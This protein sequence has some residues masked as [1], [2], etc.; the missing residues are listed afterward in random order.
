V[1]LDRSALEL[2]TEYAEIGRELR[3]AA[4]RRDAIAAV[5]R[6]AVRRVPGVQWASVT[7]G[8]TGKFRTVA[9][10]DD[11]A[12]MVDEI[13]HRLGSGPCVDAIVEEVTFR[14]GDLRHDDRW[15]GFAREASHDHGI[16]S[17]LSYRL[18][19]EDDDRIVG[20]N[21]YSSKTDAYDDHAEVIGTLVATHGAL[22]IA[23]A[24]ARE[25]AEQM[26]AALL[27]NREIG[28]AMGVLMAT[29]KVTRDQ[30]F[31]LLRI[32]S[33]NANRKLVDIAGEV[34]DTGTLD[35]PGAR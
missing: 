22:V 3:P 25:Q 13:Q 19:L 35:L 11:V 16:A 2:A 6:L 15:P 10:T 26:H 30:A 24:S 29:Y 1:T 28:T 5:C 34:A 9:A 23:A 20:L 12:R 7:E 31:T 8:R 4:S 27:R 14:T 21:L 32:A 17:M 33:Q 18:Y